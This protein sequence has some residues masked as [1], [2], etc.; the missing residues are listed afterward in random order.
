MTPA[1]P[2]RAG[3]L[4]IVRAKGLGPARP[5][6]RPAGLLRFGSNPYNEVNSPV[7]VRV[8]GKEAEVLNTIGWPN[9]TDLY[10]M[11]LR[12]PTGVS[13]TVP[14]QITAA[15]ISDSEVSIPVR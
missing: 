14:V 2:A 11:D 6:L 12:V 1:R 9:E 8:G 13:G 10:R 4:L 15:W 3:E 7:V 5:D